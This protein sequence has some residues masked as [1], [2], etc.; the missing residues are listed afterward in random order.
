MEIKL[1]YMPDRP[2]KPRDEGLT[3]MMDKGLSIRDT[4]NFIETSSEHTD[5][6]KLGF[7][8]AVVTEKIIETKIRLY[9]ES[10][11]RVYLGGTLF[12]AF[13]IRDMFDDYVKLIERLKLDTAEISDGSMYM[14]H[15]QKL[16]YISRLSKYVTVLSEVGSKQKGVEIP[17]DVWIEMMKTELATGS[18]KVIAEARESGT[19]GIYH[20]DGTANEELISHITGRIKPDKILWEA[21]SGKQQVWFVKLL[22]SNVNLGNIAHVDV[23]P[24]ECLRLGL[25][26]DTFFDFLPVGLNEYRPDSGKYKKL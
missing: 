8:T 16:D 2:A 7:G 13:A 15:E 5:L 14:P 20:N 18:W 19:V 10:K 21:P 23:V 9:Q 25:R 3:M 6:V 12:E 26:G 24:L 17:D 1:P 22:G 4:E 11:I